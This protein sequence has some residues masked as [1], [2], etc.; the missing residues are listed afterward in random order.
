MR[1]VHLTARGF[2]NLADLDL[3]VPAGGAV[4]LGDNAHGKTSVLECLDYPVLFRSFRA[5]TDQEVVR[6][7]GTG[8]RVLLQ[9][10]VGNATHG[11][12]IEVR[13]GVRRKR[14]RIDGAEPPRFTDAVGRWVAVTFLPTDLRLIQGAATERRRYLDRMLSL[15][16]PEY[17]RALL[18]YRATLAQRNAALRARQ[19]SVA[20]AFDQSL[21]ESG[22]VLATGRW[23][24]VED[25]REGFRAECDALGEPGGVA[26]RYRGAPELGDP[27]AWEQALERAAPQEL[28]RGMTL[29]GPHRDDLLLELGGRPLRDYGSTGQQ[30]TAAVALRLSERGTLRRVLGAEPVLL[31]DDVFAELDG[32]RQRRLAARLEAADGGQVFVTAPRRDE[33]PPR[34]ALEPFELSEGRVR[35]ARVAA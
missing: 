33:L 1:A 11:F 28:G 8:F 22:A 31:L 13:R 32:D 17:L 21:A 20:R 34:L 18:R 7:D 24:W 29:V 15:A 27:A 2:R 5:G 12:E 10:E 25:T 16:D 3:E 4:F 9:A 26:L 30:R 6:W 19:A 14:I 23:R 35:G